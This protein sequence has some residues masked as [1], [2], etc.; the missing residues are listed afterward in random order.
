MSPE[1]IV[2]KA[3]VARLVISPAVTDLVPVRSILDRNQR[4]VPNP[5]IVIGEGLSR[6]EGNSIKRSLTRVYSELHVWKKEESLTGVKQIAGEIRTA[7]KQS[8]LALDAG[9]HC[10]DA[11]VSA[12]R[13]MRDPD[14]V[15]SHAVVTVETIVEEAA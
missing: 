15:T 13:F 9:F 6:D 8:R 7:L 2:Q 10:V 4:P 1:T 11:F 5:S 12:T 3:I 14:G